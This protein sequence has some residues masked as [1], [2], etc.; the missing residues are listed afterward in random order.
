MALGAG[1]MQCN[2]VQN[3]DYVIFLQSLVTDG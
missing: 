1:Q 3:K 2:M